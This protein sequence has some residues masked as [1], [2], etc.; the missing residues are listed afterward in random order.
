MFVRRPIYNRGRRASSYPD[1][2]GS[3]GKEIHFTD[4][5]LHIRSTR[6]QYRTNSENAPDYYVDYVNDRRASVCNSTYADSDR[7]KGRRRHSLTG[8]EMSRRPSKT[9]GPLESIAEKP[10]RDNQVETNC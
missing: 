1:V 9:R 5:P 4:N 10:T 8:Y 2:K 7:L 6:T 3:K